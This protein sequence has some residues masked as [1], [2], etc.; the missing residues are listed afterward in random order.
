MRLPKKWWVSR[1]L[2]DWLRTEYPIQVTLYPKNALE[3]SL[4]IYLIPAEKLEAL[5]RFVDEQIKDPDL[6]F[7][8]S[9]APE[10]YLQLVL[11]DLSVAIEQLGEEE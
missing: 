2:P 7:D 6:W 8:S 3:A 1:H 5:L 11:K 9:L 4:P 10:E